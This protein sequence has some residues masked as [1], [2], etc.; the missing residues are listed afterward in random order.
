[1]TKTI[2]MTRF[3]ITEIESN[4]AQNS[5]VGSVKSLTDSSKSVNFSIEVRLWYFV[6]KIV[7]TYCEKKL[8]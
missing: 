4:L 2:I 1:M 8:F 7:P 6:T 3:N 5:D